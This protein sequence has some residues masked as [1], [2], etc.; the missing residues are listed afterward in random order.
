MEF[1]GP[2]FLLSTA[3]S[4]FINRANFAFTK[5]SA[6]LV[7]AFVRMDRAGVGEQRWA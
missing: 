4:V 3:F 2:T 6:E 7:K 5:L 1:G